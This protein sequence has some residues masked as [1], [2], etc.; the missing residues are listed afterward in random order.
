MERCVNYCG[1][2]CVNGYCPIALA[3]KYPEYEREYSSCDNCGY[4]KGCQDCA[5]RNTGMC[6][7]MDR[8]GQIM[9]IKEIEIKYVRDDV[10][11]IAPYAG[12]DW[13]DLRTAVDV[14]MNAG[15]F[16]IIP[17]GVAM[18]LPENYEALVVPRSSTFKRYRL[19]MTNS[20]GVIDESY[21]GN[22]DEW[23]FP[24]YATRACYIPKNTRI[25]Q[26]RIIEHQPMVQLRIVE[27]L[28]GK[29]RGGF[30]STGRR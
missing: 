5:F 30:G 3:D 20:V 18:K 27:K 25:C 24:A 11:P 9:E 23:G 17:L 2:T 13:I 7:P 26:F 16:K 22:N 10:T 8:R 4:Y 21:C 14:V 19:I 1:I 12:G 28:S 6:T 15:D 29:D